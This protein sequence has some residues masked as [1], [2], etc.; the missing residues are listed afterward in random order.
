MLLLRRVLGHLSQ[1]A[2]P[3][4]TMAALRRHAIASYDPTGL[5]GLMSKSPVLAVVITVLLALVLGLFHFSLQTHGSDTEPAHWAVFTWI[6]Y[7]V[8][9]RL[10]I[11]V[12]ALMTLI[13]LTCVA[14]AARLMLKPHNGVAGLRQHSWMDIRRALA[15]V[16][17]ELLTMKRHAE[18]SSG[19]QRADPWYLQPRFTHGAI[20]AGFMMLLLATSLDFLLIFIMKLETYAMA[21][22][23]GVAGGLLMLYGLLVHSARRWKG[24]LPNARTTT[25]SDAWLIFFLLVLDVTGLALMLI[26]TVGYKGSAGDVILLVHSVMAMELVLLVSVTKLSHVLYRPMALFI[27]FLKQTQPAG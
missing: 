23:V 19:T 21:R 10:G 3:G 27:H 15:A 1:E 5:G 24:A 11:A 9:H 20:M 17:R 16:G 18:C 8:I 6:P 2:T 25:L 14:N 4:E 26:T 22:P 13:V 7:A 12:G